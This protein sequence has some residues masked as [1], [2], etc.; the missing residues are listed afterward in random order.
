MNERILYKADKLILI[1]IFGCVIYIPFF[2]GVVQEDK[3][4]SKVEKRN[5]NML[6]SIP[7]SI[8][9]FV[10][11]PK[12]FNLYYSDHFG[13][14]EFF[15][16]KYFRLIKK[17]S[18]KS[19]VDDVTF[20][21]DGWLFLGS[22]KPGY[23]KLDDPM[24]D[25][26]NINLFSDKEL[27]DF[28][29]SLMTIKNWLNNKGIEYIYVISPSKHTV[30]F[31]KLP[32]YIT[33]LNSESATDQLVSYL[34]KNTDVLVVDLRKILLEEKKKHQV[35]FKTDTHWNHYG[36]NV[37]QFEII[38]KIKPLFPAEKLIP[39]LLSDSQFNIVTTTGDLA[40]M[41]EI[42]NSV[43]DSPQ[44]V[45]ENTC[46]PVNEQPKAKGTE[47]LTMVCD[48]QKLNAVIFR[49]SFFSALQPYFSR[50]FNRSTYI[51]EA[52]N[53]TSL[54]KYVEQ[55]QP[56]IVIDEMIERGYPYVPDSTNFNKT[57]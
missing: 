18:D 44:P 3:M 50:Y 43:E 6:P 17:F 19:S 27:E 49:D 8:Q 48:T 24:G 52:M 2:V 21:Q 10:E 54:V 12:A 26:M 39:V 55:E 33:K 15:T 37:A 23:H 47:T 5:L 22:V 35:Y 56:D 42:E 38:N 32:K 7:E 41:A 28:A 31:E 53:Y 9:G 29:R 51:W 16:K 30:Y 57:P 1:F 36:A 34:Q 45:F 25:V 46:T 14:R 11:Y 20:G 4:V 40:V 13:L